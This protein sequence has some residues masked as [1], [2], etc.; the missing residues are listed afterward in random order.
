MSAEPLELLAPARDAEIGI[1]AVKH[2]ADAVYIGGPAF[3]ARAGAGNA[4]ADIAR[5]AACA[6]R[7]HAKVFVALNTILDDGE[8][9]A[10]RKLAWE[11]YDAGADAL[12][13][14]DMG[15]LEVDLPPLQ[16]H[17]STQC[18]I[19]TP[20]K[21][22]FL[23]DAGFSQIVL[24]REMSLDDIRRVRAATEPARCTLEFF[25][26]GALCVAFSGQCYI[27][28]AH[29]GRS[30]NR[31]ECSQACR[32][33]YTLEDPQGRIVAY[34]KHLLSM[35]DNDQSANLR[36]LI[37]AG[38]R[39]FKIE[40]RYKDVAFVKNTVAHYRRLLDAIL[41]E[42]PQYRPASSGH[43]THFF[44]PQPEKTFNRGATDYFV[45]GRKPDI[46]A[47]ETPKFSG[48]P[49]GAVT[50]L[51]ADWFEIDGDVELHNGDGVSY[52]PQGS[53]G[54]N[55]LAGMRI[56]VAQGRRLHPNEMP[57][58][59]KPG[60]TLYRN[61]DQAFERTLERESAER[62]IGVRLALAAAD[63]ALEL[64]LTDEDGI[65]ATVRRPAP[66]EPA[67]DPQAALASLRNHLGRLGNTDFSAT[68]IDIAAPCFVPA[69]AINAL[70]RDGIAALVAAREALRPRLSRAAPLEPPAVYPE[71]E[72]SYL[73][74]VFNAQARAFYRKHGVELIADA[75][76]A[77][78]TPGDVSLM[79]TKHCLRYSFNLCPREARDWQIKGV[80]AEPMTLVSG[81][82][83]LT[84]RFDCKAC[85][86]HVVGRRR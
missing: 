77:D 16:L 48:E 20:E 30:A 51:G 72:L 74:N 58:D 79:I 53:K 27:S 34:D 39:S 76:E 13:V 28:H 7:F 59:L 71:K 67:R 80:N 14:Q 25:I 46:G 8:I 52:Q 65:A 15:L 55:K 47:F 42:Q 78:T 57:P 24:A 26:H 56:N 10:A 45:H 81:A 31:G 35:K 32:L 41:A 86:M 49:I 23:Q 63:A 9:E 5:L 40:G 69:S 19:R 75:Y 64:T 38:I 84:L 36:A 1:E 22:R 43:C 68:Q 18:D 29:T 37:A 54:A 44:T 61:R 85:E 73:G 21:A 17:A 60:V 83:R 3:G 4:V 66:L 12:I 2:G 6:H 62:R 50:R 33:P 11:V 70:R 82:E